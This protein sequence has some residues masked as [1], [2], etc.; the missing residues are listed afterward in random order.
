M[1]RNSFTNSNDI[2][3]VEQWK[4]FKE[5]R[6]HIWRHKKWLILTTTVFA[7]L[8][9]LQAKYSKPTFSATLTFS[10]EQGK[11]NISNLASIASQ[12]GY[13]MGS[14]GGG[15]FS[16]ENLLVLMKSRRMIENVLL[17][18]VRVEGDSTLLIN[19]YIKTAPK[20][21]EKWQS[22]DLYPYKLNLE[23]EPK[24]DSALGDIYNTIIKKNLIVSKE[25]KDLSFVSVN[26][27][28]HD[29]FFAGLF[30]EQLALQATNFYIVTKT[31]NNRNNV[32]KL[33][34]RV[35]SVTA[36]LK[37]AMQSAGRATDADAY[38]VLSAARVASLEKQ[39]QVTLLTTLYGELVKN[40]EISK[41]MAAREE[42]LITV[43][44]RPHY[45]LLVQRSKAKG[46]L[47]SGALG[48]ILSIIYVTGKKYISKL[49]K[50]AV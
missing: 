7:L 11:S 2:S 32:I 31:M 26:Y 38:T 8:G 6:L 46:A 41:T 40:L 36:E 33:Q 50:V 44:D 42:P 28:G 24:Q 45:P 27:K 48:L 37:I 5:W 30:V 39:M 25:D 10:M 15:M 19:Q 12:F 16:G 13:S 20:L 4:A 49:N 9:F 17:T 29:E 35:D 23:R 21:L 43:I 22:L 18:K 34:N 14:D 1:N 3:L 47:V